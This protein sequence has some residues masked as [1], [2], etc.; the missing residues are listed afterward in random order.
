[1]A[2]L[3]TALS[4]VLLKKELQDLGIEVVGNYVKKSQVIRV[5]A[6][7]RNAS[8]TV[9]VT[10][11]DKEY[12]VEL[13]AELS[14]DPNYGADADNRRGTPMTFLEDVQ[15]E[16]ITPLGDDDELEEKDKKEI[17]KLAYKEVDKIH[18][19][20]YLHDVG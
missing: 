18:W 4:K 17:E 19:D 15:V 1:M 14:F 2:S 12:E 11:K 9:T 6:G 3:K 7:N 16:S 20:E 5:L 13:N 8:T 10:Y